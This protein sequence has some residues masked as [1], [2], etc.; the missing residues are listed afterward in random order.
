MNNK[1]EHFLG[2][3]V[4]GTHL[5]IGLVNRQGEIVAF[6]KEDT[7]PYRDDPRGFNP[8]FVD[9]VGKYLEKY[10]EV[11]KIGIGLPGLISKDRTTT[12][13]IPAIPALNGFNLKQSLLD[14]YPNKKF[15]LEN[16]A[17]AAALG[18][19]RYGTANPP[20]NFLF[21]T[22]GTGIGS[23]LIMD[24]EVFKGSRGNAME[25]GHMLS[26]GNEGL[27][28]IIGR[29]G[30][31]RI[32][33]RMIRAYPDLAGNDLIGQELG[34]HLLVDTAKKGNQ[35]S[36][37]VFE[38]VAR[39]LGEAIVSAIR[40]LDVTHVYFGGGISAGLEFMM[41]A[42]DKTVRQFLTKYYVNDL[43]LAKATLENNAGTLGAAALCFMEE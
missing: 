42:L 26:R 27:E 36:I 25:M 15:F 5:K 1:D 6:D 28:R 38:E 14:K 3:D 35:V 39:V 24:G 7:T 33:D 37:M 22:M 11:R 12:L 34:T 40:I 23:A 9:V 43:K 32:M 16:D 17:A 8:C 31:L 19:Y 29:D 41:P 20:E 21:I 18:E 13:E 10:P 4:G 2:I 30:I